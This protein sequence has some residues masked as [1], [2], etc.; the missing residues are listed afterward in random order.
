MVDDEG[1][2]SEQVPTGDP[3]RR[4]AAQRAGETL[5]LFARR[6][7]TAEQW[8]ADLA[9]YLT[10]EALE[11]HRGTRPYKVPAMM[12]GDARVIPTDS[13]YVARVQVSTSIGAYLLTL[14]RTSADPVW[15]VASITPPEQAPA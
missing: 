9:P 11:T 14:V 12:V 4:E 10:V 1:Q 3:D 7:V 15:R 13:A 5:R 2:T 8:L 6:D